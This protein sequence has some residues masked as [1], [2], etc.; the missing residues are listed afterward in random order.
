MLMKKMILL[1]ALLLPF[2]STL[3]AQTFNNAGEYMQ[4]ISNEQTRIKKDLWNYMSA[5]ARG[6]GARVVES[7][8][9]E[10]IS[11]TETALKKVQRMGDWEDNT[12]YRDSVVAYYDVCTKVLK[13]DFAKIVDMEEIA[14]KSYD[15]MEAYLMVKEAA[16][17]KLDAAGEMVVGAQ[18]KFADEFGI[19]LID[20][21]SKLDQKLEKS[22]PVFDYYNTIYLVF[23][24]SYIQEFNMM[25]AIQASDLSTAEQGKNA[26]ALYSNEGLAKLD[27]MQPFKSDASLIAACKKYLTFCKSEA[28]EKI[29]VILDFQL[30][31]ENFEKQ[32][33]TFDAIPKNKRTQADVDS[34]NTAVNEYNASIE[35]YNKVNTELN[36]NRSKNLEAWNQ[37]VENFLGRHIPQKR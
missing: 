9:Q 18:K 17:E 19:T 37:A 26:L 36:T 10:L 8:R 14:E 24:K 4:Y 31:K 23:F 22:A 34:Y 16:N 20:D 13:E 27:T 15:A 33:A 25:Q 3:I 32:K 11:Q 28:E 21:N 30:K 2:G 12:E 35:G 1:F 6:K 7:K 5:M 29:Q